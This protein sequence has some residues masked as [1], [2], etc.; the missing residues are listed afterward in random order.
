MNLDL[1]FIGSYEILEHFKKSI[2]HDI[3]RNSNSIINV[4]S[5]VVFSWFN[6]LSL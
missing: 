1:I 5:S 2:G 3:N 4:M 6:G